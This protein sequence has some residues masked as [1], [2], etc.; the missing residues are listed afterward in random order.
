MA[1]IDEK[2]LA[3]IHMD[4]LKWWRQWTAG[5]TR[6]ANPL[7]E[8][9]APAVLPRRTRVVH[10]LGEQVRRNG[11]PHVRADGSPAWIRA[12]AGSAQRSGIVDGGM[13]GRA[14]GSPPSRM[15]A[16]APDGGAEFRCRDCRVRAG[17]MS[18]LLLHLRSRRQG[19]SSSPRRVLSGGVH[20]AAEP[21]ATTSATTVATAAEKKPVAAESRAAAPDPGS[22][23]FRRTAEGRRILVAVNRTAHL[24]FV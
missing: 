15:D 21:S 1:F 3:V 8:A 2:W 12:A 17:G 22:W 19:A 7:V 10:V 20:V 9:V 24:E 16:R 5:P 23:E 13:H 4:C 14:R 11:G 18:G 6:C